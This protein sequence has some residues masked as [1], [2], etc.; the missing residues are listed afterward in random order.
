MVTETWLPFDIRD[1][2]VCPPGYNMIQNDRR[3][4]AGD[5]AII[6]DIKCTVIQHPS[7]IRVVQDLP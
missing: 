1:S 7:D 4:R 3:G 5:V 6:V 2:E